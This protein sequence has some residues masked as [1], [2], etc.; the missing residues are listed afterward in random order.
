GRMAATP[1][2]EGERREDAADQAADVAAPGDARY[3][4]ADREV[5]DDERH[6]LPGEP[7]RRLPLENEERA[8]DPEDGAGGAHWHRR[9]SLDERTRRAGETGDEVEAEVARTAEVLLDG[10]ADHPE[11]EHVE[12]D[13]D[14]ARVQECRGDEAPPVALLH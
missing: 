7:P 4:E 1:A 2:R 6:R 11:R 8:E 13:V 14:D 5:D 12:R 9:R 10:P 3:G